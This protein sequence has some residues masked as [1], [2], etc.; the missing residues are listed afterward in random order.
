MLKSQ[1]IS[2]EKGGKIR[3]VYS[4]EWQA[5]IKTNTWI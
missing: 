3:E 4:E 2:L 5:N 1:P